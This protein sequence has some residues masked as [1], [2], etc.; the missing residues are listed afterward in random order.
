MENEINLLIKPESLDMDFVGLESEL[1]AL[2][3]AKKN[4]LNMGMRTLAEL[5]GMSLGK[6]KYHLGGGVGTGASLLQL[7]QI[8]KALNIYFEFSINLKSNQDDI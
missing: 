2:V 3:L 6:L 1:L 7:L 4:E 5:S 8:A